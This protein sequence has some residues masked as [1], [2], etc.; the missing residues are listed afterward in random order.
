MK[1]P[2][3]GRRKNI[4]NCQ[5]GSVE[6]MIFQGW[7]GGSIEIMIF[8]MM[9]FKMMIFKMMIFKGGGGWV[10]GADD[11]AMMIFKQGGGWVV[12][13]STKSIWRH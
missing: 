1:K 12:P 10:V 6:I 7:G 5:G 11:D 3:V 9:I 8:K 13:E 2:P 4:E